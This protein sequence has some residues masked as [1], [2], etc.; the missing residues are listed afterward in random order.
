[1]KSDKAKT[2]LWAAVAAVIL[3]IGFAGCRYALFD[4]HGMKDWPLLLFSAGLAAICAA[5][6]FR[7][8]KLM[9]CTALGYSAAF[10][11]GAAVPH[12]GHRCPRRRNG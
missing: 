10:L 4:L 3:G 7:A 5:A 11:F 6:F 1:M 8:K 12:T 9:L 2:P